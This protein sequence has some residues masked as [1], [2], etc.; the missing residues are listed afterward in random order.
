MIVEKLVSHL[1]IVLEA[2]PW[3]ITRP[4]G[5]L[6]VRATIY[7]SAVHIRRNEV[8]NV[9]SATNIKAFFHFSNRN[10]RPPLDPI[11]ALLSF[12]Y[13]LLTHDCAAALSSVGLD[14]YVGFLHR[15]RPGRA[16]L[17]LDLMEELRPCMADRFVLTMINRRRFEESDFQMQENGAIL[18]T[19]NARRLFLSAWQEKKR[20][21]I[22]HPYLKEKM[23]W[24]MVP[25][26]QALLLSR[27]IR[28]DLDAYPPFLWK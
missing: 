9:I 7:G 18:L 20:E 1:P 15:D 16:S 2:A 6:Y 17:A 14:A 28:G 5:Q 22:T 24:G 23:E 3:W 19:D 25:Y 21:T 13:T 12:S 4:P 26:V 27:C 8:E 10:R 11:N